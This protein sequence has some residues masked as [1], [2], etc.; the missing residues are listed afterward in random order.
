[1]QGTT[2]FEHACIALVESLNLGSASDIRRIE[3]LTGGVSSEIALVELDSR[4]ICVKFALEKLRVAAEWRAP[5]RR[6]AA[7]YRWLEF[8][9]RFAPDNVPQLFGRSEELGGFAMG[10]LDGTDVRNWK[11]ELLAGRVVEHEVRAVAALLVKIHSQSAGLDL[12]SMGFGNQGDFHSLRIEPYLESLIKIHPAFAIVIE[13]VAQQL[14]QARI[15]L[16]H[17]DVSPKNI[18]MARGKPVL[19][20]AECATTGD[21]AFD[22]AFCLNHLLLK[23]VHS[24][25]NGLSFL[26]AVETFFDEYRLGVDWE[27]H[28][29][30]ESRVARMLPLL[31][32]ARVDGKSPVEYLDPAQLDSVRQAALSLIAASPVSVKAICTAAEGQWA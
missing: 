28:A 5:V 9:S 7:E 29:P 26:R 8:V 12:D 25:S 10:F 15:A 27:D 6:N 3:P 32:L 20:D 4:T 17:G 30:F 1:M 14:A 2:E 11:T 24:P 16:V 23:A 18:L 19:L 31:L 13:D 21:P 22:V